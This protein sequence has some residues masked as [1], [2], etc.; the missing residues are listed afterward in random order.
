M[1][2]DGSEG[3]QE[4]GREDGESWEGWVEGC[5]GGVAERCSEHV[6]QC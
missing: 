4:D 6:C 5:A 2:R 3:Q 1:G